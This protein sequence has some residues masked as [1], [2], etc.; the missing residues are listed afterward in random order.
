VV[1]VS[2]GDDQLGLALSS[3]EIAQGFERL[4]RFGRERTVVEWADPGA[5]CVKSLLVEGCLGLGERTCTVGAPPQ[6]GECS[7]S[8]RL[9]AGS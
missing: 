5:S 8:H 7:G 6:A 4:A 2:Q 3:R 9:Q 1:A